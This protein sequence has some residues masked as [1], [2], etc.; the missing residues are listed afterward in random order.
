MKL[1]NRFKK[2][3]T[4]EDIYHIYKSQSYP[5]RNLKQPPKNKV[6]ITLTTDPKRIKLLPLMLSLLDTDNVY[7]I[8]VNIP[9]K[10][11]NE[12][13][14]NTKDIEE[15]KKVKKVK[16]FRIEKDMGPIT[17]MLPTIERVKDLNSIIISIDD[18]IVYPRGLVNEMIY[19]SDRYPNEIITGNGFSFDLFPTEGEYKGYDIDKMKK[20]WEYS[21]PR[22]YPQVDVAEGFGAISYRKGLVNIDILH[23]FNDTSKYCKLS[24]DITINYMLS[25][26][27][28]KRRLV[29]NK[30]LNSDIIYP[31]STGEKE[32]LHTQEPPENY[33]DYNVYKYVQ[34]IDNIN[35]NIIGDECPKRY[36]KKELLNIAKSNNIR[37]TR[38]PPLKGVKNM[39]ELCDDIKKSRDKSI[40]RKTDKSIK[41]IT[42]KSIKR[43]NKPLLSLDELKKNA[44]AEKIPLYTEMTKEQLISALSDDVF[45]IGWRWKYIKPNILKREYNDTM[46]LLLTPIRELNPKTIDYVNKH[47]VYIT[48]TTAPTRLKRIVA[49]LATLDLSYVDKINVVLPQ[50]YGRNNEEYNKADITNI[51]K[52]PKVNIIRIDED[53]GPITKMLPTLERIKDKKTII[54]SIDDDVGYSLSMI[55]DLIYNKVVV[56]P[57]SVLTSMEGMNLHDYLDLKGGIWPTD[58]IPVKPYGDLIEGWTGVC[59]TKDL[60]TQKC[61]D[62]MKEIGKLSKDCFF[63]DDLVISY[64]LIKNNIKIVRLPDSEYNGMVVSYKYGLGEDALMRGGGMGDVVGDSEELSDDYNL[65][66]YEYCL[67]DIYIEKK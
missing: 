13:P 54:I 29:N 7:K 26:N 8:H 23:K 25:I 37:I 17:K 39:K 11:R 12:E 40:K 56:Y 47:K 44:K 2:Y 49:V 59:Y 16:V 64:V 15:L 3:L 22:R 20:W 53:Y 1:S 33:W 63:S 24:D 6:Y 58:K 52:F 67:D 19:Q 60:V 35:K 43:I 5:V 32:G 41:R 21:T 51:S 36:S 4:D 55:N 38:Y 14:Y 66:K 28:V 18:D 61:L 65:K 34:C 42:D 31:L 30:Y 9:K 45:S 27:K 46:R 50:K 10:Y 48:M 62:E 57:D